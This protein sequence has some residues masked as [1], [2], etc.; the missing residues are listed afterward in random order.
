MLKRV[1][2]ERADE[3]VPP[4]TVPGDDAASEPDEA[5]P[6]GDDAE[7]VDD[8]LTPD[9]EMDPE[10]TAAFLQERG[11]GCLTLA[12]D[13][14]AYSIPVSFGYDGESTL[15]FQLQTDE[16]SE[17][18]AYLDATTTATF[19]VPRVRP[20]NWQSAVVR[21]R[22]R[23]VSD[24]EAGDALAAFADN[25]WFPTCPWTAEK[26]PADVA[27]YELEIEEMSGRASKLRE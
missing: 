22:I 17:K 13:D 26:D 6:A 8:E 25:A 3:D 20:P 23:P 18:L 4:E 19:L 7:P 21:G 2:R 24:D 14:A 5:I 10:E 15:Y 12:R 27:L 1:A 11:W 16:D 9:V